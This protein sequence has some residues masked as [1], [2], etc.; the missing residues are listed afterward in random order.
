[1]LFAKLAAVIEEQVVH[2]E[3]DVPLTNDMARVKVPV[4]AGLGSA[5]PCLGVV[6]VMA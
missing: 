3:R 5:K 4:N 1:V 2:R 6:A